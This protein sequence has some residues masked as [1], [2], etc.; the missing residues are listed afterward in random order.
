METNFFC[1]LCPFET[2]GGDD[3]RERILQKHA[4]VHNLRSCN[5]AIFTD[6]LEFCK[7][8]QKEHRANWLHGS[9]LGPWK[10]VLDIIRNDKQAIV[11]TM[12]NF[13][14]NV[15]YCTGSKGKVVKMID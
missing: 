3:A 11:W 2:L 1:N 9:G 15:S 13:E 4:D 7:H 10:C 5:Q 14:K 12:R 8:L 6:M